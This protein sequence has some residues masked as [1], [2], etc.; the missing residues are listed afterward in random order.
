MDLMDAIDHVRQQTATYR[1]PDNDMMRMLLPHMHDTPEAFEALRGAAVMCFVPHPVRETWKYLQNCIPRHRVGMLDPFFQAPVWG[2]TDFD[3]PEQMC[4]QL[5]RHIDRDVHYLY[6][7]LNVNFDLT[8]PPG[9]GAWINHALQH[10]DSAAP[11]TTRELMRMVTWVADKKDINPKLLLQDASRQTLKT[12]TRYSE[13]N[14]DRLVPYVPEILTIVAKAAGAVND[15]CWGALVRQLGL[16]APDVVAH[17]LKHAIRCPETAMMIAH[18]L[19]PTCLWE[20]ADFVAMQAA[21]GRSVAPLARLW[22]DDMERAVHQGLLTTACLLGKGRWPTSMAW[23]IDVWDTHSMVFNA[24]K[25]FDLDCSDWP[26]LWAAP[27]AVQQ[28]LLAVHPTCARNLGRALIW[29]RRRGI[30][31]PAAL[32]RKRCD[33]RTRSQCK[34][35]PCDPWRRIVLDQHWAIFQRIVAFL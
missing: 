9:L 4:K 12:L 33:R 20:M 1:G 30:V 3:L 16:V 26:I 23:P 35:A 13:T 25:H 2:R 8:V 11:R 14:A 29:G 5:P 18:Y 24:V 22:N 19:T 6:E 31:V 28:K 7:L 17:E 34:S 21:V 15:A 32:F 27:V 10:A